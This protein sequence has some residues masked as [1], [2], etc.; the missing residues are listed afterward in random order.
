M[1]RSGAM[2]ALAVL[3]TA[4]AL[5]GCNKSAENTLNITGPGPVTPPP[6]SVTAAVAAITQVVTNLNQTC[7]ISITHRATARVDGSEVNTSWSWSVTQSPAPKTF[8]PASDGGNTAET[9]FDL[10]GT[11]RITAS[12]VVNG[13][14]V[15]ADTSVVLEGSGCRSTPPPTTPPPPT[16]TP[17]PPPTVWPLNMELNPISCSGSGLA[18]GTVTA[19]MAVTWASSNPSIAEVVPTSNTTATVRGIG[20]G[21]ATITATAADG[22][23]AS[24]TVKVNPC[25]ATPPP[26]P[27]PPPPSITVTVEPKTFTCNVGQQADLGAAVVAGAGVDTSVRWTIS[28]TAIV[29]EASRAGNHIVLNCLQAGTVTVTACANA[30]LTKCDSASGT[31]TAATPTVCTW[32]SNTG[33]QPNGDIII[34]IGTTSIGASS[35]CTNGALPYWTSSAPSR[36]GVQG[37]QSVVVEGITFTAGYTATISCVARGEAIVSVQPAISLTSPSFSRKVICQ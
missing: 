31:V 6:A 26:S 9:V 35:N 24:M 25:P 32:T 22:Q 7:P 28:N 19:N 37:D 4:F 18:T 2:T 13:Q 30:D 16:P 1:R 33:L 20:P 12:A 10:P 27:P 34:P 11:Y 17:T 14:T 15:S 5:G 29:S 23:K 36:V 21:T 3:C 8:S